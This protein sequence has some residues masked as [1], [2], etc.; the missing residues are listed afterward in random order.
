QED[1]GL[2]LFSRRGRAGIRA[3]GTGPVPHQ[4][5]GSRICSNRVFAD[6]S[7]P[8]KGSS[9]HTHRE[10]RAVWAA[11]AIVGLAGSA[12]GAGAGTTSQPAVGR[13][14]APFTLQ[15]Y[16]GKEHSLAALLAEHKSGVAVVFI[17][18]ECPL[19]KL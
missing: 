15:D 10:R 12:W 17:G 18:T 19:A 11:L 1:V 4:S 8:T 2:P 6:N 13:K 3:T 14:V 5:S 7:A 9:M 16:R